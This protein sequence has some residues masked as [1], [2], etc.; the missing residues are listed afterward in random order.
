MSKRFY[1]KKSEKLASEAGK[2]YRVGKDL[3]NLHELRLLEEKLR[4]DHTDVITR[5]KL[6]GFYFKQTT[7]DAPE[8]WCTH[9]EWFI[10]NCPDEA[11]V[12]YVLQ[13]PDSV[14]AEQYSALKEC[15]ILKVKR[16]PNNA[17]VAGHAARFCRLEDFQSKKKF[18]KRARRLAPNNCSW[19]SSLCYLYSYQARLT[20]DPRIAEKAFKVG[21][22]FVRRF[23]KIPHHPLQVIEVIT[24][25]FELALKM[26]DLKR[27][28]SYIREMRKAD[29][30]QI[31]SYR[32]HYYKGLLVLKLGDIE[33]AKSQLLK[34]ARKGGHFGD[35]RLANQ[36]LELG[37]VDTVIEYLVTCVPNEHSENETKLVPQW[38]AQLKKGEKVT[39]G[40]PQTFVS[41]LWDF[42]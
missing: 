31:G 20:N 11:L 39:L 41:P 8:V 18:F 1:S 37:Q 22:K 26:G 17:N 38:I 15:F 6:L 14:S 33:R 10:K 12:G 13:V 27:S 19:S 30:D 35:F 9:A 3:T 23:E 24:H 40:F 5:C 36:L 34:F 25:L 28:S 4:E 2:A 21:D 7:T 32:K 42:S 29:F 16:N